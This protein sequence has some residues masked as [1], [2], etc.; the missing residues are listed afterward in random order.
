MFH[1]PSGDLSAEAT[2]QAARNSRTAIP[3]PAPAD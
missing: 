3:E 2:P 1:A